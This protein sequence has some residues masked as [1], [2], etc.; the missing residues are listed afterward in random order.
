MR[1]Q[2][3]D[4][5]TDRHIDCNILKSFFKREFIE[6]FSEQCNEETFIFPHNFTFVSLTLFNMILMKN[7]Y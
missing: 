7:F 5:Q 6:D 4:R 1:R 2:N 3:L